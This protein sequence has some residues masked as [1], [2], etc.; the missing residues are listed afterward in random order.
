M[1][2]AYYDVGKVNNAAQAEE[3]YKSSLLQKCI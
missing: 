1:S 2:N 3:I